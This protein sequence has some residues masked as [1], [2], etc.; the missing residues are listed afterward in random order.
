MEGLS[1][2][3]IRAGLVLMEGPQTGKSHVLQN[4]IF[5]IF[6]PNFESVQ[7]SPIDSDST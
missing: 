1:A 2:Q 6:A 5:G 7:I 3:E 4:Y